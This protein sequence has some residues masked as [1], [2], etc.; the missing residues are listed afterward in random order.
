MS[1]FITPLRVEMVEDTS[2]DGRGTWRL[3]EPLAYRSDVA[4]NIFVVP[5]GFVTDFASVPRIPVA[6]FLTGD[7]CHEAA[8]LHDWL[9]TVHTVDKATADKVLREAAIVCGVPA[10]RASLVWLGVWLGGAGAW[11]ADGPKQP[12]EIEKLI[13]PHSKGEPDEKVFTGPGL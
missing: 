6:F 13:P 3:L 9:Y 2:H 8:V 4:D 12:P 11:D 5:A 7:T 10:W 1:M